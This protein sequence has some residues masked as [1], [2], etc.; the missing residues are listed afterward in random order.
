MLMRSILLSLLVMTLYSCNSDIF[1]DDFTPDVTDLV[2]GG[3]DDSRVIRF[4]SDDWTTL[5]LACGDAGTGAVMTVT[6]VGGEPFIGKTLTGDGSIVL[7]GELIDMSVTRRGAAVTVH[8]NYAVGRGDIHMMLVASNDDTNVSQDIDMTV[9]R[10]NGLEIESVDYTL[11]SWGST[12][13]KDA[14]ELA[15]FSLPA[16]KPSQLWQPVL[17]GGLLTFYKM[18]VFSDGE[19]YLSAL[20]GQKV[21]V[22]TKT[23]L[24]WSDWE[25]RGD[26]VKIMRDLSYTHLQHYPPIPPVEVQPGSTVTLWNV[27]EDIIFDFEIKVR[28][29][30]TGVS[31]IVLMKLSMDQTEEYAYT[32]K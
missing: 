28:N 31:R 19:E 1:V 9:S 23:R 15:E 2:L 26:S 5:T 29:R 3:E 7:K 17:P 20:I 11:H 14:Y 12:M 30:F 21:P 32:T 22:P 6:P 16:S 27:T 18:S 13:H 24:D 25:L 4:H 10:I 8:V